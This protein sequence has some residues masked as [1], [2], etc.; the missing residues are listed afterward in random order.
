MATE[1]SGKRASRQAAQHHL[2]NFAGFIRRDTTGW[3]RERNAAYLYERALAAVV[4][5]EDGDGVEAAGSLIDRLRALYFEAKDA[6]LLTDEDI[7]QVER[8]VL[9]TQEA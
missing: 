6:G 4:A 2:K 7:V 8:R 5:I 3:V 1:I 9:A